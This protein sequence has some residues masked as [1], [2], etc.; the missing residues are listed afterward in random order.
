MAPVHKPI[1]RS[2]TFASL[3]STSPPVGP[4]VLL[5]IISIPPGADKS[6]FL[7]TWR[8]SAEVLKKAPGYIS[9]QLHDSIG[10]GNFLVN[11]AVWENNE[12]L[13]NG[14][15]LPEFLEVCEGFPDGTEFRAAV[16][17]KASVKDSGEYGLHVLVNKAAEGEGLVDIVAVHGLNGHYENTWTA[18]RPNGDM[19]NWL[20]T[21]LPNQDL[22]QA[23][24][25]SFS[26]N[27]SVQFSKSTSDAFVFA[28]QLLEHL[29]G[30][31]EEEA[32][33][34]RPIVFICH[35]LGG[36]VVKQQE[37]AKHCQRICYFFFKDDTVEQSDAIVGLS[38]VLYQL[39]SDN[40]ELLD[41]AV[42][43]LS[44]PG[45][46]LENVSHLWRIFEDSLKKVAASS[47]T[48]CLLDGLDECE[49]KSRK[50]LL[51]CIEGFFTKRLDDEDS[52]HRLK[53]LVLSRPDNSIKIKFDR[54]VPQEK[55]AGSSTGF[56]SCS[57][58]RLRGEDESE[59]ISKD[60][61]LVVKDAMGDLA[62]GGLPLDLLEGVERDLISRA[63]RTFLWATLIIQL[64]KDRAIEGASR[65]EMDAIL[66]SRDVY[67]IYTELLKSKAGAASAAKTKARKMLSLILGAMKTLTVDELNVALAIKPDHD[68]FAESAS[69]RKTSS[70]TFQSTEYKIVYP[71]ENHIKSICG[72]FVRIIHQKVYLV[73]QTAREF[74]LDE[75]SWKDLEIVSVGIKAEEELW[76]LSD[77]YS[78]D[79]EF[80]GASDT[81]LGDS[82]ESVTLASEIGHSWQHT[83]SLESCHA[84]LLEIC[85]T[86]LYMLA[87]PCKGAVLGHPTKEVACLLGYAA[88]YWVAHFH[89][90]CETI[91]P[92]NLS[93]YQGLCHP[94]FP[95]FTTWL[96]VHDV[97]NRAPA[98]SSGSV[99]EQQDLL[100]QKLALE[101]GLPGFGRDVM[102]RLDFAAV[103]ETGVAKLQIVSCNPSRSQNI[104]FP[105]KADE[106][107]VVSLDFQLAARGGVTGHPDR[108]S[109]PL[110]AYGPLPPPERFV[111]LR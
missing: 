49:E 35:S 64:L 17:Q 31:R 100:I 95:G 87:K 16:L 109:R 32:E 34:R 81:N 97:Q 53:M 14:L 6:A 43:H 38:A 42:E 39:Y 62:G 63:D 2:T 102:D 78:E 41:A 21:V 51:E 90:V 85:T 96:G 54:R 18:T 67:S 8:R 11:Y 1:D 75:A 106:T 83:F 26:Y 70:R 50:Q 46:S 89:K 3:L 68:T 98:F 69:G 45:T 99:E 57:I 108:D 56:P 55:V 25:M 91:P 36:I 80:H 65:R 58:V 7:E 47:T 93:Y 40:H 15:A 101:P 5:N 13:K 24:V 103:L 28:D 107:G 30:K 61:E 33:Q 23:R 82:P 4:V 88:R 110:L 71:S 84:L 12:D 10:E 79:E 20:G 76:E 111:I 86:Y 94:R 44:V 27:S 22:I 19:V 72:H 66:R 37:Q 60:I 73:H 104:V 9:T 105:V 29:I 92:G 59:A 48:I 74:L 52:Q 77:S